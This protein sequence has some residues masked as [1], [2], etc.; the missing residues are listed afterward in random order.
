VT[1]DSHGVTGDVPWIVHVA[2][3]NVRQQPSTSFSVLGSLSEGDQV[4]GT[5]VNVTETDE[6]WLEIDYNGQT[7]YASA[8]GIRRVHPDNDVTGDLTIGDEIV[9]RWW[10]LNDDYVP[11]DITNIASGYTDGNT[12]QYR[13]AAMDALTDMMDAASSASAA[14]KV[15]SA[16]RSYAT[17][18][19]LYDNAVTNSGLDQ[20]YSAPPGHSEHQLGTTVDLA[21]SALSYVLVD[22]FRNTAQYTWL[23]N[24]AATYGF[25]QTYTTANMDD[26]WYIAEPWHW[27]YMGGYN[28]ATPT[29]TPTPTPSP[30]PSPSPSPTATPTPSPTPASIVVTGE[31]A[32]AATSLSVQPD[33]NDDINGVTG[34]KISGG[35]HSA[36]T[37]ANDKEPAFTDG[38][39]LGSLTGLL[40]DY[41]GENTPAWSGYWNLN[42]GS[43]VDLTE[44]R[45]FAGNAG[46]DTRVFQH[47]DVYTTSDST[48]SSGSTWTLLA[49]EVKAVA[50][51]TTNSSWEAT[52]TKVTRSGGQDL[53]AG[54]TGIR[55]DLYAAGDLSSHC[56]DDWDDGDAND[57]DDIN[58]AFVSPLLYEIDVYFDGAPTPTPTPTATPTPTPTPTATASPT[59]T[60]TPVV[61]NLVSNGSFED[62]FSAG[63]VGNGWISWASGW[64]NP[65]T[66]GSASVNKHDG[67]YSQYWT[68][69]S[70]STR[71]HGGVFQ[72]VNVTPGVEYSISAWMKRQGSASD[73]WME[74]GYDLSGGTDAES[75]SVIYTKLEGDGFNI[76]VDYSETVTATGNQ[77]TLFAKAGHYAED[78]NYNY[79]Y[80]D[81]IE[82]EATG[83]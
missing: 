56:V 53:A 11:S 34:T 64:S 27:R 40:M 58:A 31:T 13:S 77:I 36:V 63:G 55:F 20:R 14:M 59:P 18:E 51:G 49:E 69:D 48:V 61:S 3:L 43:E 10:G 60:A 28:P 52:L 66:F 25:R 78:G 2:T 33:S 73:Q 45:V 4:V 82:L 5:Y 9:E 39:G 15:V 32:T 75:A 7:G 83:N 1:I 21:D 74:F 50:F 6:D 79:F 29:P 42:S 23:T 24:N 80:L 67:S 12:R 30:T 17:Q 16:Y 47:Y 71:F 68:R 70:S 54:V 65:I 26:T 57:T 62:G 41:P 76:W 81:D 72:V 22:S 46:K 19:T 44:I 35:F 37:N 38:S 8:I